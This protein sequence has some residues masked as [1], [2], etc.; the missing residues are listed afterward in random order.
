M[1][2]V[3]KR[4]KWGLSRYKFATVSTSYVRRLLT[5]NAI[6]LHTMIVKYVDLGER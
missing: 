6:I 4:I 1:L 2:R 5:T 3:L